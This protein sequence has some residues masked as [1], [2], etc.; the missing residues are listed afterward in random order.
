MNF[1]DMD[2]L[3]SK[4]SGDFSW[5]LLD[6]LTKK[7]FIYQ[8]AFPWIGIGIDPHYKDH[9]LCTLELN[10]RE[11]SPKLNKL[12]HSKQRGS[13]TVAK[14]KTVAQIA[15]DIQKRLMVELN[16]MYVEFGMVIDDAEDKRK[17]AM[18]I[19]E[20]LKENPNLTVNYVIPEI[21]DSVVNIHAQSNDFSVDL[22][23]NENK[24]SLTGTGF[25]ED[26]ISHIVAG[27]K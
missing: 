21:I 8:N 13:I 11:F 7:T 1:F 12:F 15:K 17:F 27:L 23:I 20:K 26:M 16:E 9:Y 25:T 18:D 6:D 10:G 14:S 3:I 22:T 2:E 24:L 19:V 5:L 4:F